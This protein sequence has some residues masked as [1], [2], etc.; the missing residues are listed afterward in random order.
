MV[1]S[2]RGGAD[3][4]VRRLRADRGV[5]RLHDDGLHRE[6]FLRTAG[7]EGPAAHAVR[8][9][10]RLRCPRPGSAVGRQ[11]QDRRALAAALPDWVRAHP[12]HPRRRGPDRWSIRARH[13]AAAHLRRVPR[14]D[15]GPGVHL[16]QRQRT[17]RWP[18]PACGRCRL[19]R[20]RRHPG[21][22]DGHLRPSRQLRRR[23]HG[24]PHDL[25]HDR[26]RRGLAAYLVLARP[27]ADRIIESSPTDRGVL[28]VHHYLVVANHT[29]GGHELLDAIR[30][31]M[32][33]GTAEFW[34]L[35]PAT[36][37]THLVNDFNAL[38]G[39]FPIDPDVLPGAAD[40]QTRDQ[41]VAEA[42][43]N[44]DT[45]LHRLREIG[46]TADGAVGDP[47]PM[48]AIEKTVAQRRFDE[49]I[50]STLPPGISR[51]L[52]W[53]LPHRVRRRTDVP[54]TVIAAPSS[55]SERSRPLATQ[56]TP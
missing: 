53:D 9:F 5:I 27:S 32:S 30:D 33:R 45:E 15:G 13:P 8:A 10:L 23:R 4:V 48:K 35:A 44:L 34:I 46:A 40:A 56:D 7:T 20:P 29:L 55:V 50:L 22:G 42:K 51:W 21:I 2:E 25:G 39:A 52:A 11:R 14:L 24:S 38:S 26:R 1:S 31:R 16:R 18:G 3:P 19:R 6:L 54:L 36:P 47:D 28:V 12:V 17:G 43:S 41:A 37:T 49:I